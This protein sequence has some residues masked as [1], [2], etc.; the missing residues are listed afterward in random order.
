MKLVNDSTF[1][2][3]AI[4]VCKLIILHMHFLFTCS[5]VADKHSCSE[6]FQ[7]NGDDSI[8]NWNDADVQ[9]LSSAQLSADRTTKA[10]AGTPA[11]HCSHHLLRLQRPT[12][13]DLG[14]LEEHEMKFHQGRYLI[15]LSRTGT[16][17]FRV[18]GSA[19]TNQDNGREF[20]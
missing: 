5:F 9:Q 16:T 8:P 1:R 19:K 11:V 4:A 13:R 3:L 17:T 14:H 2:D 7:K 20:L 10:T 15:E 12:D 6:L 18:R